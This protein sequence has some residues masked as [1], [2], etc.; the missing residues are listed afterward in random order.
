[1]AL[2]MQPNVLEKAGFTAL[3]LKKD[4]QLEAGGAYYCRPFASELFAFRIGSNLDLSKGAHI[5]GAHIDWPCIRIKPNAQLIKQSYLQAN[6]EVYGGPI[7]STFF[8]R[9]LCI[10]GRLAVK[11]DNILE[12]KMLEHQHSKACSYYCQSRHSYEPRNY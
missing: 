11:S 10:A 3:D 4:W 12:P 1:M 7:L 9:P 5:A 2:P 6:V 8:D